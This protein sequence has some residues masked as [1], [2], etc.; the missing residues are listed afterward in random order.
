MGLFEA[1]LLHK[2]GRDDEALKALES[3]T[4]K[5]RDPWY[6]SLGSNLMGKKMEAS[7]KEDIGFSP[8]KLLTAQTALG[9]WAEGSG[10][11]E[12]AIEHYKVALES[13]LD[14]WIEFE[15]AKERIKSLR[16][17]GK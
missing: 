12:K 11:G 6:R 9:F 16:G 14:K 15:F 3:Y 5:T 10:D 2:L 1:L 17:P 8:E 7:L 13:L 4:Q